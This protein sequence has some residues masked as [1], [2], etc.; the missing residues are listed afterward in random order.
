MN[1]LPAGNQAETRHASRLLRFTEYAIQPTDLL[2]R[3]QRHNDVTQT[4]G[5]PKGRRFLLQLAGMP[6]KRYTAWAKSGT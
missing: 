6:V 1:Y 2:R 3:A 4:V 5:S